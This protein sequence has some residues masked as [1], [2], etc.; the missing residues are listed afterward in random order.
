M[1]LK[2]AFKMAQ[3]LPS[4]P[5]NMVRP[6][7]EAL[8]KRPHIDVLLASVLV[9]LYGV[10]QAGPIVEVRHVD[11]QSKVVAL[12]PLGVGTQIF[13]L[14][15]QTGPGRV[16][17]VVEFLPPSQLQRTPK[18]NLSTE[19]SA[20][21]QASER[22]GPRVHVNEDVNFIDHYPGLS[23]LLFNFFGGF[24]GIVIFGLIR[25][26]RRYGLNSVWRDLVFGLPIPYWMRFV[27]KWERDL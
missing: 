9:C 7:K 15:P 18:V 2:S 16:G 25:D 6:R 14:A 1:E 4:G 22:E 5:L 23:L 19:D 11:Q 13:N 26:A 10:A 12:D 27:P 8:T 24:F 21:N 20:E 17:N 3:K